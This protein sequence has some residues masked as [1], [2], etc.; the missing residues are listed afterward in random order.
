MSKVYLVG[1]AEAQKTNSWEMVTNDKEVA[2][3]AMLKITNGQIKTITV[4]E[5]KTNGNS[6]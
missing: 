4:K 5:R 1:D 3:D 6:K 2:I